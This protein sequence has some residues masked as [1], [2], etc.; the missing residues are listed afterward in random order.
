MFARIFMT[1]VA[2]ILNVSVLLLKQNIHNEYSN[3]FVNINE[4]YVN[5]MRR[6]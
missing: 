3:D 4:K 6:I 5:N 1:I 2:S